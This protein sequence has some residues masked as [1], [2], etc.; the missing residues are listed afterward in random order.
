MGVKSKQNEW[1]MLRDFCHAL[2]FLPIGLSSHR[3]ETVRACSRDFE[4]WTKHKRDR[5]GQVR[6]I[7]EN[8]DIGF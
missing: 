1:L 5:G 8:Y 2:E 4:R 3:N 6:Y 7:Q